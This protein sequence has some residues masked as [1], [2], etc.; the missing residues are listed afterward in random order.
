MGIGPI[1][2]IVLVIL[3]V[4]RSKNSFI[5]TDPAFLEKPV[6]RF[7]RAFYILGLV[8]F[9]SLVLTCLEMG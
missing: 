3:K 1:S 7:G 5:L 4:A 2:Y 8:T 9:R 6:W